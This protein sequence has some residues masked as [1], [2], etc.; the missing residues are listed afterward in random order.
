MRRTGQPRQEST[1]SSERRSRTAA[2]TALPRNSTQTTST[3]TK[4]TRLLRSTAW[5]MTEATPSADQFS[6]SRSIGRPNEPAG[7]STVCGA[8]DE[9]RVMSTSSPVRAAICSAT[10]RT[11]SADR[12]L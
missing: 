5:V 6:V 7:S 10:S 4:S 9:P 8:P 1:A 11:R 12:S 2:L 3:S